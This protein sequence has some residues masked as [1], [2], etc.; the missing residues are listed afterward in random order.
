MDGGPWP[1]FPLD[2][3]LLSNYHFHKHSPS[4]SYLS[5]IIIH[6]NIS[7]V[8]ISLLEKYMYTVNALHK[9]TLGPTKH[10]DYL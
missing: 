6:I 4:P 7:F 3:F 8:I 2:P 5:I 9:E 10:T 1:D